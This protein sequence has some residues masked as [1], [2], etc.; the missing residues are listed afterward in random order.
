MKKVQ[1]IQVISRAIKILRLLNERGISLGELARLSDLPRSTVQ[2]IVETLAV[3]NLVE[4]GECGVRLGWGIHELARNAYSDVVAQLRHPLEMLFEITRETVEISTYYGREVIFLDRIVSDQAVRVVPVYNR[5]KPIYAMANGKAMLSLLGNEQIISILKEQ[6][7]ALTQNTKTDVPTLLKE[8][9]E[10]RASGFSF[11][12]EEHAEGICAVGIP[13]AIPGQS[14]HAISVVVPS[15][16]FN[17]RLPEIKNALSVVRKEC[18]AILQ[19]TA[20]RGTQ[21]NG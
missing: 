20:F 21:H 11:D 2:R 13:L 19:P 12:L 9:D 1:G 5:P 10:V 15:Y 18:M 16:R 7:P 17:D 8:I 6:M 14:A 3:E 4:S